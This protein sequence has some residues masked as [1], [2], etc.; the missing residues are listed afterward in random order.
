MR[1]PPR[2]AG[3]WL[4]S[5]VLGAA[6]PLAAQLDEPL[7]LTGDERARLV[8]GETV[9]RAIPMAGANQRAGLAV[10]LVAGEPER[11][12]RAVG[13]VD[14]WSEWVP[15]LE[16]SERAQAPG[17]ASRELRFD[18]PWPLRDR[19]YRAELRT[20]AIRAA[21]GGPGETGPLDWTLTWVSVPESGNV[22]WARGSFRV[23]AHDAGR[24][25]VV[26]RSATDVGEARFARALLDRVMEES[27]LW[28][29]DGLDQQV[30]RCRYTVPF[31][32][33]CTEERPSRP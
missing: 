20:E 3:A 1:C 26:F 28:V 24:S 4:A 12:A 18:L 6:A 33:G 10:R 23:R 14:H 17:P 8:R 21:G 32:E 13:D 27:L 9:T 31:P 11:V 29:L 30:N 16:G 5:L 2:R 22:E 25:L 19:H 15:F 7:R